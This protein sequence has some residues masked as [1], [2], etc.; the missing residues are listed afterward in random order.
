MSAAFG[1]L[2]GCPRAERPLAPRRDIAPVGSAPSSA[3]PSSPIASQPTGSA[4]Q[5][6]LNV[7]ADDC[8]TITAYFINRTNNA[9]LVPAA[10]WLAVAPDDP[11]EFRLEIAI[12]PKDT[13]VCTIS[14]YPPTDH[15]KA[16]LSLPPGGV[17][18]LTKINL[19]GCFPFV[20]GVTFTL[21]VKYQGLGIVLR[22][23]PAQMKC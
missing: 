22:A 8:G 10:A 9:Q 2:V 21:D 1:A 7:V 6:S 15:A 18:A 19:R 11:K 17:H 14:K 16:T 5:L 20:A 23:S 4:G 13:V 12:T 3:A